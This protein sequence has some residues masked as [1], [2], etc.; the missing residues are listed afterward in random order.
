MQWLR[1]KRRPMISHQHNTQQE[2]AVMLGT[3]S[4]TVSNWERGI[5]AAK[6]PL[7]Q[8]LG[9]IYFVTPGELDW[10]ISLTVRIAR[11][12]RSI[13]LLEEGDGSRAKTRQQIEDLIRGSDRMTVL[14]EL[15]SSMIVLNQEAARFK[16]EVVDR[17]Q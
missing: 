14:N 16:H 11:T 9:E 6:L 10:A 7:K 13:R 15:R 1:E 8:L 4:T 2:I 5:F 12:E 17:P 3:V